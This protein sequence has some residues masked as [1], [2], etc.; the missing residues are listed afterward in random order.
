MNK[1]LYDRLIGNA[2]GTEARALLLRTM[3][4]IAARVGGVALT[5]LYT[6]LLSR[7]MPPQA[8]GTAMTALSTA[9]LTSVFVSMNIESGSM[10]FLV[11]YLADGDER[12]AA[13]FVSFIW[14]V[15]AM[16]FPVAAVLFLLLRIARPDA[17]AD[18]GLLIFALAIAAAPALAVSRVFARHGTAL[19]VVLR[20]ALPRMLVR[21]ILFVL[22]LSAVL[23]AG[24]KISA[25]DVV[26][27]FAGA[28]G[29]AAVVQ[30]ILLRPSL[31][32]TAHQKPDM[33]PWRRWLAS[34]AM[35]SPMLI[36][37]EY[38][39]DI[40]IASAAITM[41]AAG[42]AQ[43]AIAFS[44]LGLISFSVTAVDMS[45]SPKI[46]KALAAP[47]HHRARR[48]LAGVAG[49]KCACLI[50]GGLTIYA[51]R[52]PILSL[53][54][55]H[56]QAAGGIFLILLAIPGAMAALGPNALILNVLGRHREIMVATGFGIVA[57][58]L[59]TALGGLF[60]GVRAAAG[61]AAAAF[62]MQQLV[63]FALSRKASGIDASLAGALRTLLAGNRE[64]NIHAAGR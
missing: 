1:R 56:Y 5:L 20:S 26:L 9:L 40:V 54:G 24:I 64:I 34:G 49:L 19:D 39:K 33:T 48:L 41:S 63:L 14:R 10:R 11:R 46:A 17:P 32:F 58:A 42:V 31:R 43:L 2:A 45:F 23:A 16:A 52:E 12:K 30:Y 55:D 15:I 62:F 4:I 6:A 38:R 61:A 44:L 59:A 28:A 47:D 7:A 53:F 51:L 21:P 36:M 57:I 18:D 27:V 37:N 25:R 3:A 50:I 29:L 60:S 35:L 13:G 22:V 8:L